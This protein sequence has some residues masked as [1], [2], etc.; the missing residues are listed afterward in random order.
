LV[1]IT[2]PKTSENR[3]WLETVILAGSLSRT[4]AVNR[5]ANTVGRIH[6]DEPTSQV[7]SV[8]MFSVFDLHSELRT[9][10]A[11]RFSDRA[12]NCLLILVIVSVQ[13]RFLQ[14]SNG[15]SSPSFPLDYYQAPHGKLQVLLWGARS[16]HLPSCMQAKRELRE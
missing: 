5:Q 11:H 12:C 16:G 6:L 14:R 7:D 10:K 2:R 3:Y 4:R 1:G 13:D 8:D 15:N 9:T